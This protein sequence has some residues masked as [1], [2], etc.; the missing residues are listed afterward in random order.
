[1]NQ[2][3]SA[4]GISVGDLAQA[5]GEPFTIQQRKLSS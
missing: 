1:M 3:K 5:D 4:I 2:E